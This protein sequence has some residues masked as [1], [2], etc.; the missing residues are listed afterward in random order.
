MHNICHIVLDG[1]KTRLAVDIL[2]SRYN[3]L[4]PLLD[5]E[6]PLQLWYGSFDVLACV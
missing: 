6:A 3:P 1:R 4:P 5:L 2:V